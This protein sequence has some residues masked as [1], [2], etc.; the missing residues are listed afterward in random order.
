MKFKIIGS[1][2]QPLEAQV[3]FLE[4]GGLQ[5]EFDDLKAPNNL[6]YARIKGKT[7]ETAI[8]D[9]KAKIPRSAMESGVLYCEIVGYSADGKAI[10]KVVCAPIQIASA[11]NQVEEPLCAYP[12]INEVLENMAKLTREVDEL[13][14]EYEAKYSK[15]IEQQ[16]AMLAELKKIAKSYNLGISLFNINTEVNNN[17]NKG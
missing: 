17:E 3:V 14:Q 9:S 2:A 1:T 8:R 12:Q 13:K 6:L 4:N 16:E 15:V 10:N 7:Y 11:H 5:L